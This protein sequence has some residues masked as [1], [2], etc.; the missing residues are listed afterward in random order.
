MREC[1]EHY[2]RFHV[3]TQGAMKVLSEYPWPGNL[4]QVENFCER[5]ILTAGKRSLDEIAVRRML[6][7]L[8]PVDGRGKNEMAGAGGW[9]PGGAAAVGRGYGAQGGIP[10]LPDEAERIAET[11]RRLRGNREKTAK[12]LG[13]SKTTLW[14][15][16]KEYGIE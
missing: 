10:A 14:R 3:L 13:M 6:E 7:E 12:E 4:F 11:L 1:C 9:N 8:Y 15:R 16:M 5:L 2:S